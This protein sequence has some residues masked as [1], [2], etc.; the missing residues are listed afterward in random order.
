MGMEKVTSQVMAFEKGNEGWAAKQRSRR[1]G[2][3]KN[4]GMNG[5]HR[6]V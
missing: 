3:R 5:E 2:A 1:E 6:G 4:K